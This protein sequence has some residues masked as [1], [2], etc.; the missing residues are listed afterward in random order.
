MSAVRNVPSTPSLS[1]S[2]GEGWG[3]VLLAANFGA[4]K[5]KSD[6]LPASPCAGRKG[7]SKARHIP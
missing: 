2:E 1:R 3:G 5:I 6:P 4:R 7:R